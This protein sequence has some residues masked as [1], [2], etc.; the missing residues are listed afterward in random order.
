MG[1]S[2]G[3]EHWDKL[4]GLHGQMLAGEYAAGAGLGWLVHEVP[5]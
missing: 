3:A 4:C 2:L 5:R 1:P